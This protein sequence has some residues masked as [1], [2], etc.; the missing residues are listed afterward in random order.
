MRVGILSD[1]HGD[2]LMVR[3]AMELFDG[4]HARQIIHCGDV[5]GIEVF[6]EML[7]RPCHF[8]QGN[9]DRF[10]GPVIAYLDAVGI[11]P[12]DRIPL[13][14]T[15]DGKRFAVFHGHEPQAQRIDLLDDVDY[16]LHGHS[17]RQRD[18]R[19]GG[20]RIINPGALVRARPKTVAILDPGRDLLTFHTLD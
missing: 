10:N 20:V 17:H 13:R 14:F 5:G 18:E 15:L 8:V 1:S 3:R 7:G 16:V 12:P 11:Q 4:Q 6:D 9:C 2:H 19:V